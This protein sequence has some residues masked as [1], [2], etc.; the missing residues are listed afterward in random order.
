MWLWKPG[1]SS[2]SLPT[3]K[4]SGSLQNRP[5]T[6]YSYRDFFS[7]RQGLAILGARRTG[8]C[9]DPKFMLPGAL[10]R[11]CTLVTLVLASHLQFPSLLHASWISWTLLNIIW[12]HIV[13]SSEIFPKIVRFVRWGRG[14][15]AAYSHLEHLQV[16][17]ESSFPTC[18]CHH[19]HL[20][21]I[22]F[23]RGGGDS[24]NLP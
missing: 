18:F 12:F 11:V 10:W 24:P 22:G 1:G 9:S 23:W 15:L 21:I 17:L 14:L 13:E 20:A 19:W 3:K 7:H 2:K 6:T 16:H 5:S 4:G 8:C